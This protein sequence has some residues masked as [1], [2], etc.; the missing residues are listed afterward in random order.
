MS[1]SEGEGR[2]F[3]SSPVYSILRTLHVYA[4]FFVS[5][6]NCDSRVPNMKII[7]REHA[8]I[9]HTPH[10]SEIRPLMDRTTSDITQ[11][12]LAEETLPAGARVGRHYHVETE[13][14]YYIVRG[15]G[16]MTID[17][18][19]RDVRAGDCIFI[20]RGTVHTLE[21]SG[22]E[23]MTILLVCGPAYAIADHYPV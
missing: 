13:E 10:K 22:S 9:I 21:N 1:P 17:D 3:E 16:R 14:V 7:N 18:E 8:A 5:N 23:A 20:P 12:S 4:G 2:W 15:E 6:P 11:C 19:T